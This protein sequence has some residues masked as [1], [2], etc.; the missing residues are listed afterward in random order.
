MSTS[1]NP[2]TLVTL[3][4]NNFEKWDDSLLGKDKRW[5]W[6]ATGTPVMSNLMELYTLVT[7]IDPHAFRSKRDFKYRYIPRDEN[8]QWI[9]H[10]IQNEQELVMKVAPLMFTRCKITGV[11]ETVPV[12]VPVELTPMQRKAYNTIREQAQGELKRYWSVGANERYL[13]IGNVFTFMTR[14]R[15]IADDLGLVEPDI[16]GESA[17]LLRLIELMDQ[18]L[19]EHKVLIFTQFEQ[20]AFRIQQALLDGGV[21]AVRLTGSSKPAQ[22][23]AAVDNFQTRKQT[24]ALVMTTAGGVGLNIQAGS[25]VVLFDMLWN[26]K[27]MDQ[28][29]GRVARPGN[30]CPFIPVVHLMA[31]DTI[32]QKIYE[33]NREKSDLFDTIMQLENGSKWLHGSS[34]K[35][36]QLS[37]LNELAELLGSKS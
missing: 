30:T 1:T 27:M 11:P 16:Q 12:P 26:P 29:V 15:Q 25:A 23:K 20:M 37:K 28:I 3:I 24:R 18:D 32:E 13:I 4:P 14:M 17:K 19:L 35:T 8:G 7:M 31:A 9:K 33:R 21:E 5:F 10:G 2:N 34:A 36:V 6:L 22:R